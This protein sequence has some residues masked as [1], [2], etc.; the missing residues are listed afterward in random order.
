[1]DIS[2][3][4]T[5]RLPRKLRNSVHY[6]REILVP[7]RH[8]NAALW[9]WVLAV[10]MWSI[11][12]SEAP[13]VEFQG[14][15]P[16]DPQQAKSV[17]D[18]AGRKVTVP[19]KIV[20]IA[21]IGAT[22]VINSY[23]FALGEGGKI[24]NG[25]PYFTPSK[26]RMQIV[27]AP[28]LAGQ[29]VLQGQNRT[30]NIEALLKLRPDVVITMDVFVAEALENSGI[31]VIVLEW[32]GVSDIKANMKILGYLLDRTA[33]SDEYL[34]YFET[35]TA[36]VRQVLKIV[37]KSSMPKV[38]FFD[39]NTLKTPL[40]ITEWWI[41]EAGGLSVTAKITRAGDVCYSH[42]QVLLWNPDIMIV[43]TPER[44]AKVYQD[45]RLSMV[46]AVRNKKV[47]T[48]PMGVHPWG[49]RTVEQPLTV[50]WAAKLF[51]PE[52]FSHIDLVAE[53][54]DFYRKFFDYSLTN[55]QAFEIINGGI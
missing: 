50:L 19:H 2:I 26:W 41:R 28:H 11:W 33:R 6:L 17:T 21:T 53:T 38:L 22:P 30:I 8:R 48:V 1:M 52:Q 36:G 16:R 37:R 14:R 44:I 7:R 15:A 45:K 25:L 35:T 31:P 47:Y 55:K 34:R 43:S 13:A 24:I 23:L 51:Y 40:R 39:P 3:E 20:R 9:K 32:R 54:K 5:N 27:I 18:M 12:C 49:Q 29:P 10:C 42:E 4:S 46:N